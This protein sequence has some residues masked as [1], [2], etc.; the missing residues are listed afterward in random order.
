MNQFND[1]IL[2]LYEYLLILDIRDGSNLK[3]FT[4]HLNIIT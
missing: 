1:S 2:S 3:A 4:I